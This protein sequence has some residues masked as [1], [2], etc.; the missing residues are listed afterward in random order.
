[1]RQPYKVS[2]TYEL[3][4]DT[5]PDIETNC[6][7]IA[8]EHV[9]GSGDISG[10]INKYL[11]ITQNSATKVFAAS[12]PEGVIEERFYFRKVSGTGQILAVRTH[13]HFE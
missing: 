1:M 3:L 5:N 8:F 12:T 13:H 11:V 10:V 4:S 7:A 6:F 2:F 9:E